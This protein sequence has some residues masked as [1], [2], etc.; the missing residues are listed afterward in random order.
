[1]D[2]KSP[3]PFCIEMALNKA[4]TALFGVSTQDFF[5]NLLFGMTRRFWLAF[6]HSRAWRS[7]GGGREIS[8]QG[9]RTNCRGD[10]AERSE[11]TVQN[12]A[13]LRESGPSARGEPESGID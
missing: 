2:R 8:H 3:S 11:P 10:R 13:R 12:D 6:P 4:Y 5:N 9:E 1:M 7:V